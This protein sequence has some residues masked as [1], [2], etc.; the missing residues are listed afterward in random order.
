MDSRLLKEYNALS[1]SD[2]RQILAR[3]RNLWTDYC[4]EKEV[5][6]HDALIAGPESMTV[7]DFCM[8]FVYTSHKPRARGTA[9]Q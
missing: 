5:F 7:T 4:E 8:C 9:A 6:P 2:M 1:V 3:L